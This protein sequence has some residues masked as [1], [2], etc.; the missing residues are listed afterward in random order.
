MS[1]EKIL[2]LFENIDADLIEESAIIDTRAV[3]KG[4]RFSPKK[5]FIVML[6]AVLVMGFS[7]T[8]V[9]KINP[10]FDAMLLQQMGLDE[11]CTQL[12]DGSVQFNVKTISD[13]KTGDVTIKAVSSIGDRSMALIRFDTNI[14]VPST[15][16]ETKDYYMIEDYSINPSYPLH[17]NKRCG[18]YAS[19][20][21]YV[22]NNGKVS[23]VLTIEDL[24]NLN[25]AKIHVCLKDVKLHHDLNNENCEIKPDMVAEGTWEME[26]TYSYKDIVKKYNFN[27]KMSN[28]N[29]DYTLKRIEISPLGV[30]ATGTTTKKKM[31]E[32]TPM[33]IN[34]VILKDGTEINVDGNTVA[35][36][37]NFMWNPIKYELRAY[38]N[39]NETK[40][41][42]QV[43]DVE[44]VEIDET[45]IDLK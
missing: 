4:K 2:D 11:G 24:D 21:G 45:I 13:V 14:E 3:H 19:T 43:D 37:G 17:P 16:D 25:S 7:V 40:M 41:V 26:W 29:G 27:K 31:S 9:A 35:G 12:E 23:F 30:K 8:A 32:L 39:I 22:N 36:C 34:K 42:F 15:F 28:N 1:G 10:N 20:L 38:V 33:T 6:A 44:A 18:G 5:A